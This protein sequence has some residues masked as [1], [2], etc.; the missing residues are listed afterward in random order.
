LKTIAP[1]SDGKIPFFSAQSSGVT[2]KK[3]K[4]K[5]M[6]RQQRV[7]QTKALG[8]ADQNLDVLEK[9]VAISVRKGQ[10]VQ[11]RKLDWNQINAEI[12]GQKVRSSREKSRKTADGPQDEAMEGVDEGAAV[13]ELAA[14]IPLPDLPQ[15]SIGQEDTEE[16]L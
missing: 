5:Q 11:A 1:P 8:R 15:Q 16:I 14:A 13:Q 6:S 7:R 12:T 2:K 3:P 10:K 4:Q 9:K